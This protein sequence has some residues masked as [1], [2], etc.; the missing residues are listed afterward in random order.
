LMIKTAKEAEILGASASQ[1][2]FN[3]GNAIGA[4]AGGLPIAAGYGYTSPIL[5]GILMVILGILLTWLLITMQRREL[6]A[7]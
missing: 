1:A 5:I 7:A 6:A 2:A 3:M 4:F